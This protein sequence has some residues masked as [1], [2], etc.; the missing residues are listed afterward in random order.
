MPQCPSTTGRVGGQDGLHATCTS[1]AALVHENRGQVSARQ[2]LPGGLMFEDRSLSC[3]LSVGWLGPQLD[4]QTFLPLSLLRPGGRGQR[5][6]SWAQNS[7]AEALGSLYNPG[8]LS[9]PLSALIV[10]LEM[11]GLAESGPGGLFYEA[12]CL[13]DLDSD[14]E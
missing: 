3:A 8:Q 14:K 12:T 10:P 9:C 1:G 6:R 5:A 11:E 2:H 4:A 7:E 13:G